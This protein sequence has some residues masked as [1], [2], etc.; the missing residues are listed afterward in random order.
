[1]Q[2]VDICTIIM[3]CVR[4]EIVDEIIIIVVV[5]GGGVAA[6]AGIIDIASVSGDNPMG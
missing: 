6:V 5:I 3:R 1:M 2:F 4:V